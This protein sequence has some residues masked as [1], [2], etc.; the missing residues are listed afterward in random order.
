MSR[1]VDADDAR[2]AIRGTTALVDG[3][4]LVYAL[5]KLDKD[6]AKPICDQLESHS[7]PDGS[8]VVPWS[9]PTMRPTTPCT[10]RAAG[11]GPA[12]PA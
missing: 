11:F 7:S 2:E 5:W 1:I 4:R 10:L 9:R 12:G 3:A 8:S 6:T